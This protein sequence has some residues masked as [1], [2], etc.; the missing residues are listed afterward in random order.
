MHGTGWN[1]ISSMCDPIYYYVAGRIGVNA[2]E[3][4]TWFLDGEQRNDLAAENKQQLKELLMRYGGKEIS[5]KEESA[6]IDKIMSRALGPYWSEIYSADRHK[7]I[8]QT[9]EYA[10]DKKHEVESKNKQIHKALESIISYVENSY[11]DFPKSLI[12]KAKQALL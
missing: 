7:I 3:I 2:T 11:E 6:L 4:W 9:K 8:S 10:K 12:D 1:S 5:E